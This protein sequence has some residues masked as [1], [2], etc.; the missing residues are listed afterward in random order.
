MTPDMFS[1]MRRIAA[2]GV[3]VRIAPLL[4]PG[5]EVLLGNWDGGE[6]RARREHLAQAESV[7][8]RLREGWAPGREVLARAPVLASW[9]IERRGDGVCL[10]GEVDGHP[11]IEWSRRI[12]TSALIA[13]DARRLHWARTVSRFYRLGCPRDSGPAA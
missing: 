13:M 6:D 12:R 5:G 4:P 7:L 1:G 10:I 2:S 8:D 9:S 11:L 3:L